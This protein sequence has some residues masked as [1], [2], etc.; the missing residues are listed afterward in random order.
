MKKIIVTGGAGFI[1][2]NLCKELISLGHQVFSIDNY[3]TGLFDNHVRG[4][5]YFNLDIKD[6]KNLEIISKAD[7]VYHL[8]ALARIQ[9]SFNYPEQ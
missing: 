1:G 7:V 6:D 8:A 9:P 4:V 5:Y 3:S 2:A